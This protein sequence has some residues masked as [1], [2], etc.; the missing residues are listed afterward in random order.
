MELVGLGTSP[1][2]KPK[3]GSMPSKEELR[4]LA[5][6]DWQDGVA[7]GMLIEC[8]QGDH[9]H[10]INGAMTAAEMYA[11]I[12]AQ[13]TKD[14][15]MSPA[16]AL[17]ALFTHTWEESASTFEENLA[18]VQECINNIHKFQGLKDELIELIH[19]LALIHSLPSSWSLI[20]SVLMAKETTSLTNVVAMLKQHQQ[21]I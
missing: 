1:R 8:I 6:W 21:H 9:M 7:Q 5:T 4:N 10:L 2:L 3:V 11:R 14:K 13:Y 16:Y 20:I 17:Q 19:L 15:T 18:Y 12:K